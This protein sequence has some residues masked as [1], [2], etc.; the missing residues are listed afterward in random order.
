MLQLKK[1][2]HDAVSILK[3]RWIDQ[4]NDIIESTGATYLAS[5]FERIF[6]WC[7]KHCEDNSSDS[8]YILETEDGQPR[9]VSEIVDASRA[10]DPS[11]KFL[12][13]YMEPSLCTD[14]RE[15]LDSAT[16]I[17]ITH[18]LAAVVAGA[19]ELAAEKGINKLKIY[20]RTEEM[21]GVFDA[22][23]SLP[24]SEVPEGFKLYKQGYKWLVI[25]MET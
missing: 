13:V 23:L 17:D 8:V 6:D 4:L 18:V 12:N 22:L 20:S 16:M 25:E 2:S 1:L 24:G 3:A 10:K 15:R 14:W 21:N 19:A 11:L 7:D 9:A 5:D